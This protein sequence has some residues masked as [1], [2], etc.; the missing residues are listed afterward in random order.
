MGDT[1]IRYGVD[2]RPPP[3][4]SLLLA[5][6]LALGVGLPLVYPVVVFRSAGLPVG[7]IPS[8]LSW[9]LFALAVAVLLQAVRKPVGTGHLM[10][11]LSSALYLQPSVAAVTIGGRALL[12]GMTILAGLF[13]VGFS[14]LVS[15]LR[16]LFPPVVTGLIVFLVG[17]EVGLEA[18]RLGVDAVRASEASDVVEGAIS[19]ATFLVI[20][21]GVVWGR[22]WVRNM[23]PVIGVA[24]GTALSLLLV[25][26]PSSDA[27]FI[28]STGLVGLPDAPHVGVDLEWSLV[29]PFLVLGLAAGLRTVGVV[30]TLHQGSHPGARSSDHEQ[31]ARGVRVDG[32][33]AVISGAVSMPGISSSPSA[34]GVQMASGVMSRSVAVWLAGVLAVLAFIP[35]AL[36]YLVTAPAAVVSALLTYY[37]SFMMIGGVKLIFR[38][39]LDARATFIVGGSISLA[40]GA[41]TYGLASVPRGS[42][43]WA[44]LITGS[45]VTVGVLSAMGLSLLFRIGQRRHRTFTLELEGGDGPREVSAVVSEA[46]DELAPGMGADGPSRTTS[47]IV[48]EVISRGLADGEVEARVSSDDVQLRID[49]RY[50][51]RPLEVEPLRPLQ[52]DDLTDENVFAAGLSRYLDVPRPDDLSVRTRRDE[53]HV[54]LTY[55]LV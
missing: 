2:D 6:Q 45:M 37:A 27:A 24:I 20:V 14:R 41:R 25:D 17:A 4:L 39:R 36:A 18:V 52:D 42:T 11:S 50:E 43:D 34:V 8:M 53:V 38:Q 48:A 16:R 29:V 28:A 12:S 13:E 26:L 51:G 54:E 10:P 44:A 46:V 32:I 30:M 7:E 23:A 21:A 49:L 55:D 40:L 5:L 22:L 47:M 15:R 33:G 9:G 3:G 1:G 31:V 35:R 19:A